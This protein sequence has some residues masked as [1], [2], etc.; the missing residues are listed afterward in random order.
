MK[1]NMQEN[2]ERLEGRVFYS[3]YTTDLEKINYELSKINEPILVSGVGGSSVVSDYAS[4]I[5]NKK[6]M[7]LLKA[8]NQETLSI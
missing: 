2:F 8:L 4:K 3:L 6:K 1:K 7:L 5:I